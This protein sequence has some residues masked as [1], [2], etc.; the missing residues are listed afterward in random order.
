MPTKYKPLAI[1]ETVAILMLNKT[2]ERIELNKK[3]NGLIKRVEKWNSKTPSAESQFSLIHKG[4]TLELKLEKLL[5]TAQDN[6]CIMISLQRMFQWVVDNYEIIKR[7]LDRKVNIRIITEQQL[8]LKR[9]KEISAL[10]KYPN[11]E[12]RHIVSPPKVWFRI[13]DSN[14]L[15]LSVKFEST[16]NYAVLTNNSSLIELA[17][18]YFNSSW[19]SSFNPNDQQFKRDKRQFDYLFANMVNGFSYNKM[20]FDGDNE[21]VD[22]IIIESNRAF[23]ELT[24]INRTNLGKRA[25]KIWPDTGKPLKELISIFGQVVLT[26]TSVALSNFSLALEKWFSIL[27]YSPENGYFALILE[28][29]TESKKTQDMLQES[30]EKFRNLAE[31]SPSMIF[32]NKQGKIVYVNRKCEETLGYA[33]EEF[34][35][36]D[37]DFLTL[38]SPEFK[39]KLTFNFKKHL[40]GEEV[41]TYEYALVTKEGKKIKVILTSKIIKYEKENAILGIV[42]EI[43]VQT[44]RRFFKRK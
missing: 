29:I 19:F 43:S 37:F 24:G 40:R 3:A 44:R 38:I 10:E 39:E 25:T 2:K 5:E 23:E 7:A 32:I 41:P 22:F 42:T 30:E 6:I 31:Q 17:Q 20:I 27:V 14:D 34:Y 12:I 35:S 1:M 15:L 16:E 21:P 9:L 26:G 11:F 28:D 8:N 36:S 33:K 13:Y 4:K 18:N